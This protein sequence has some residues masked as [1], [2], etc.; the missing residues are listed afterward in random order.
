[1][2]AA[3]AANVKRRVTSAAAAIGLLSTVVQMARFSR[4]QKKEKRSNP[5]RVARLALVSPSLARR[6]NF[7]KARPLYKTSFFFI[8]K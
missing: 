6:R 8:L 4:I 5:K 3:A 1:V 2:A 7:K